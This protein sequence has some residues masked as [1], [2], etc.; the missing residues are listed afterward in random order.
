MKM[1][2]K[3]KKT[4]QRKLR[5]KAIKMQNSSPSKLTISEALRRVKNSSD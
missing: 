3:E 1:T 4:M 5:K 2:L